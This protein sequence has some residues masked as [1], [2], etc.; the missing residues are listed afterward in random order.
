[1]EFG[2]Q[3][4]ELLCFISSGPNK[5]A[6]IVSNYSPPGCVVVDSSNELISP[7]LQTRLHNQDSLKRYLGKD[8][9]LSWKS[10]PSVCHLDALLHLANLECNPVN[11]CVLL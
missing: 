8:Q 11:A 6:F 4:F 1:M 10:A 5:V 7:V 2:W 9:V 3:F